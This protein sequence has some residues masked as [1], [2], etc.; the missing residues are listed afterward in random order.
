M[1]EAN[2]TIETEH[3][4]IKYEYVPEEARTY[5][6]PGAAAEINI[7]EVYREGEVFEDYDSTEIEGLIFEKYHG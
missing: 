3:Y 6:H 7:I 1:R 2:L 4:L 5:D